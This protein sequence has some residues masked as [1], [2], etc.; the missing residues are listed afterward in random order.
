[1]IVHAVVVQRDIKLAEN[2]AKFNAESKELALREMRTKNHSV[3]ENYLATRQKVEEWMSQIINKQL[4]SF[5]SQDD[6]KD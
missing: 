3:I 4:D 1:M 5:I 6:M 2:A